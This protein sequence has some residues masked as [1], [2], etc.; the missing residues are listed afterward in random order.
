MSTPFMNP[1]LLARLLEG[2]LTPSEWDTVRATYDETEISDILQSDARLRST[3]HTVLPGTSNHNNVHRIMAMVLEAPA[4][5]RRV[6]RM[7][8]V[9]PYLGAAMCLIGIIG[10]MS[11][12]SAT[13]NFDVVFALP[14]INV[15]H[16]LWA[17][18]AIVLFGAGVW[19]MESA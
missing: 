18:A 5:K 15:S 11:A 1:D 17:V 14:S 3:L 13:A 19:R 8:R 4:P 2:S 16:T 7:I 10:A 6:F 9:A 12:V